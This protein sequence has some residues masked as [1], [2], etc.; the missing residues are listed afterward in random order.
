LSLKR[1]QW[2][3]DCT[4]TIHSREKDAKFLVENPIFFYRVEIIRKESKKKPSESCSRHFVQQKDDS[5]SICILCDPTSTFSCFTRGVFRFL[6]LSSVGKKGERRPTSSPVLL[7]PIRRRYASDPLFNVH[8]P[9]RPLLPHS[10]FLI[11]G[12]HP[13]PTWLSVGETWPLSVA[14]IALLCNE[15]KSKGMGQADP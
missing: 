4:Y 5:L 8:P 7:L 2:L 12:V 1:R 10:F 9:F 13:P 15:R 3:V 14:F 6:S 11:A